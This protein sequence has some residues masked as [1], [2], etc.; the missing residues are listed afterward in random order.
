MATRKRNT[1]ERTASTKRARAWRGVK[2]RMGEISTADLVKT[3]AI[4]V[5]ISFTLWTKSI[6]HQSDKN[7]VEIAQLK[8]MLAENERQI[9]ALKAADAAKA[10]E[11]TTVKLR[12]DTCEKKYTDTLK[13]IEVEAKKIKNGAIR[14]RILTL[15]KQEP[16]KTGAVLPMRAIDPLPSMDILAPYDRKD[17]NE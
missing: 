2:S 13:A 9:E 7:Q 6:E 4:I 15:T 3:A 17:G 14:N 16:L 5:T 11:L 8:T 10:V 12:V 1:G